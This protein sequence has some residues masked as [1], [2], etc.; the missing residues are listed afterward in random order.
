MSS[1]KAAISGISKHPDAIGAIRVAK[2]A[3]RDSKRP[4]S[5]ARL[6]DGPRIFPSSPSGSAGRPPTPN[7]ALT[8]ASVARFFAPLEQPRRF[9]GDGSSTHDRRVTCQAAPAPGALSRC[10]S[11]VRVSR[12]GAVLCNANESS[13]AL[14]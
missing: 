11:T 3:R 10:P 12:V 1:W 14:L 13:L 9:T 7:G 2:Q 6:G 8:T 4:M 5:S